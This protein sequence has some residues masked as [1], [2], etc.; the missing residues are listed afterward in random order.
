MVRQFLSRSPLAPAGAT[1][2]AR[3]RPGQ[4]AFVRGVYRFPFE[5]RNALLQHFA[6]PALLRADALSASDCPL[7]NRLQNGGKRPPLVTTAPGVPGS[8]SIHLPDKG[9]LISVRAFERR[10]LS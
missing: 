7:A 1:P 4:L 2:I 5:A 6:L 3:T 9:R 8:S 10:S